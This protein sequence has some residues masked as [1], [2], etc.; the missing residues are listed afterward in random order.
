M[1]VSI[2]LSLKG[3]HHW[4]FVCDEDDPMV[5][6]LVSALPGA[7]LDKSL[8]PDGLIQ[9]EARNGQRLFLSRSSLV[10]LTI[11]RLPARAPVSVGGPSA[12][13]SGG[14]SLLTATPFLMRTDVFE[15]P[16]I[17]AILQVS[18]SPS[19]PDIRGVPDVAVDPDTLPGAA[20]ETLVRLLSDAMAYWMP[21][22]Y[23][24]THLDLGIRRLSN[25]PPVRLPLRAKAPRLLD[26]VIWL[27]PSDAPSISM[28]VSLPDRWVGKADGSPP[29]VRT[30]SLQPNT[31]L[32][33]PAS[34]DLESLDVHIA[35]ESGSPIFVSGSLCKGS[36]F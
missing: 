23:D 28:T 2:R 22:L 15:R 11:D 21:G 31:A 10:A 1:D 13:V 7:E 8:P 19:S 29:T 25:L 6:G 34:D 14:P 18:P 26:F 4:Q 9:V 36:G 35:A 12:P 32:L 20:A 17:D 16:T 3:G 5:F 24:E 27:I 30:L 33:F